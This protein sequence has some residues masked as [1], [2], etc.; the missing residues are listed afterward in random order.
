VD[1]GRRN[2][3]WA[4]G[5][6]PLPALDAVLTSDSRSQKLRATNVSIHYWIERSGTPFLVVDNVGLDIRAGEFVCIVGP[7]GC[8]KTT[9][10]NAVDGLQPI[11]SGTLE[12]NGKPIVKPGADRAMVFQ[13]ASLVP[14]RTVLGNVVYG[15]ELERL[16]SAAPTLN[17]FYVAARSY[18]WPRPF[19]SR[20]CELAILAQGSR[21]ARRASVGLL[22]AAG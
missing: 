12:L 13:Q 14:W 4:L 20:D 21:G 11:S 22:L 9:F 8:G 7:S 15:L 5:H 19:V 18:A 3:T 17:D 6:R 1:A 16:E 2:D 10:L